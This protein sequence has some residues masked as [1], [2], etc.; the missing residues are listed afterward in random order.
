MKRISTRLQV[1]WSHLGYYNEKW[2]SHAVS[3]DSLGNT[4]YKSACMHGLLMQTSAAGGPCQ[5]TSG[6]P[7]QPVCIFLSNVR[8]WFNSPSHMPC[9][10]A[11][12]YQCHIA[13]V[14]V[15]D[16]LLSIWGPKT[17]MKQLAHDCKWTKN[18]GTSVSASSRGGRSG[19]LKLI[20]RVLILRSP[21]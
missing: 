15:L 11:N 1:N 2:S 6:Q 18:I 17:I 4:H 13:L 16:Q 12:Q 5:R 8:E 7:Q 10:A 14:V 9:Y 20:A 21:I 3:T 19:V